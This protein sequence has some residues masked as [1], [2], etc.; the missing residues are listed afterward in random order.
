MPTIN[1]LPKK[2]YQKYGT[3]ADKEKIR[4]SIYGSQK[5]QSLRLYH[6]QENP[7]CWNCLNGDP[8]KPII[9][10]GTDIHHLESFVNF[11]DKATREFVAYNPTNLVTL[12]KECHGTL[13]AERREQKFKNFYNLCQEKHDSK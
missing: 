9:T 4:K 8:D 3:S 1:R 11:P 6:L 2:T 5:W 12:C 7:L 10:L 13:H